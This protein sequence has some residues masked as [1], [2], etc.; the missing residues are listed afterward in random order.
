[1]P[2]LF[3]R[4]ARSAALLG[5]VLIVLGAQVAWAQAAMCP[6]TGR[7]HP[8]CKCCA[9]RDDGGGV[10]RLSADCCAVDEAPAAPV[11]SG[12]PAALPPMPA[13]DRPPVVAAPPVLARVVRAEAVVTVEARA[14]GPPLWLWTRSLRL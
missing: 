9:A 10:D 8:S 12:E 4:L 11:G 5:L 13:L 6:D 14:A 2:R 3:A 1:M 7:F